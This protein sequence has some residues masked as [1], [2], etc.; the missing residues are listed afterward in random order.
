MITDL[1][2][3]DPITLQEACDM[4]NNGTSTL[5]CAKAVPTRPCYLAIDK[6]GKV[7]GRYRFARLAILEATENGWDLRK[8]GCE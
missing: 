6:R 4:N 7:R 2:D 3:D 1:G 5:I 8:E